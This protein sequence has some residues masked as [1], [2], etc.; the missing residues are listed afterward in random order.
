M[1][2][3]LN[4]TRW[5]ACLARIKVA[6][7]QKLYETV[8]AKR[9]FTQEE[10]G[11]SFTSRGFYI[12]TLGIKHN[13]INEAQAKGGTSLVFLCKANVVLSRELD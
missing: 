2:A 1:H 9:P 6:R 3:N 13:I 12:K 7:I 4:V 5:Q 11:H 8:E 10:T